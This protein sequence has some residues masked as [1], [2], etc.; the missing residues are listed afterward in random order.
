MRGQF[1]Y[2]TPETLGLFTDR[3]ELS[4]LEGYVDS[5]HD[6][7]A[8]FSLFVRRLPPNRGYL[9][10]AGLEQV[11]A[12]LESLSFGP[13]ALDYLD[14]EGFSP[15]TLSY[16][17]DFEFSGEVRAVTEG[18]PVF[19]DEPLLEVT[20]PL[21][22]AQLFETLVLNQV[23]FQTLVATKAARM[24]EAVERWGDDQTL[25]DFGSRRAHGVD[26]GLKAARAASV[27]GFDATSNVAAGQAFG[28]PTVG[29]MAH[30]WVQSFPTERAAFEA[31]VDVYGAESVLLIDTYDT[32]AG[33]RLAA[34]VAAAA[35]TDVRGV[36]LDSGELAPLSRRVREVLGDDVEILV[37]SGID[38]FEIRDF[39]ADGGDADGFGPGTALTTSRDAPA[40]DV[41]YKLVAVAD[42]GTLRP[43]MKLSTGKVTYPG[44][45]TVRRVEDGG[46][47]VRD[48]VGLADEWADGDAPG[49]ELLVPV[50]VD[51]ERVRQCPALSDV[52]TSART[53]RRALPDGCRDLTAPADYE[54]RVS[55]RLR[56]ETETLRERLTKQVASR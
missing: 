9:L 32:V 2:V 56:E 8:T 11:V 16:L 6:P 34:D 5:G 43:S 49:E 29:T 12:Y 18:T 15:A 17:A 31:F 24:R 36:R 33:A 14:A 30:S 7:L 54:V 19:P 42:G 13:A 55:D 45:K 46:E 35:D 23:G 1:G 25:V 28:V 47:Y 38:E 3:Y 50:F 22:E 21:P 51:G 52:R 4:M 20:A 37:S 10:A 41:V 39:L 40:M 44:R 26:A 48:V 53:D 27:G